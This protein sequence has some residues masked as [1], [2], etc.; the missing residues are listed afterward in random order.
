MNQVI[1][2]NTCHLLGYE[3]VQQLINRLV[4][5][6]PKLAEAFTGLAN[7]IPINIIFSV[8]QK[9]LQSGIPIID[10]RTIAEKMVD[11]WSKS[12]DHDVLTD[13]VRIALRQLIVYSICGS[14]KELPVAVID[15][16]LDQM[17]QKSIQV[18][19]GI[20][21]KIIVLEPSLSNK[22][23]TS[24]LEYVQK[25]SLNSRP[26]ILLLSVELRQLLERLFKPGIPNMHFLSFAE[27]PEDKQIKIIEKIG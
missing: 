15:H 27:I 11:S 6:D 3:E 8:L 26:I 24:L 5:T 21:E 20:N 23:Y 2:A 7:G 18:N 22:I 14:Q 25:C 17:L 10:F 19:Q 1:C 16:D 12:K 13:A 9:L 4:N